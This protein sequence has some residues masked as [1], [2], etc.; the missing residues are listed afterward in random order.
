[1]KNIIKTLFFL[2]LSVT[3]ANASDDIGKCKQAISYFE[4]FDTIWDDKDRYDEQ[5]F[6]PLRSACKIAVEK[7]PKNTE[8]RI[9][10]ATL[11]FNIG[12][13][14]EGI[15][16]LETAIQQGSDKAQVTLS[17]L[18]LLDAIQRKD[19]STFK[20]H[21]DIL[22]NMAKSGNVDALRSAAVW[23]LIDEEE[24]KLSMEKLIPS[25]EKGAN[26][27]DRRLQYLLGQMY[28]A[29]RKDVE[30][31]HWFVKSAGQG[32]AVSGRRLTVELTNQDRLSEE[33]KAELNKIIILAESGNPYAQNILAEAY[34]VPDPKKSLIWRK[35]AA[36]NGNINSQLGLTLYYLSEDDLDKAKYWLNRATKLGSKKA[37]KFLLII[38]ERTQ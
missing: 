38:E 24:L 2:C 34:A 1:M 19:K 16:N 5:D 28:S 3:V 37:K 32:N 15:K 8:Y 22:K 4:N 12:E 25:I 20:Q 35:K 11:Q 10:L 29:E 17:T 9:A 30:S 13:A 7:S 14:E 27:G 18:I 36:E 23:W 26:K 31:M 33:V 21:L 6:L